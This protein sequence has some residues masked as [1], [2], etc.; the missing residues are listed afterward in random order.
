M[1]AAQPRRVWLVAFVMAVGASVVTHT[2][3]TDSRASLLARA[4]VWMPTRVAEMNVLRGPARPDAFP[5][6]SQ[7]RCTFVDRTLDGNSPKF[8]CVLASGDEIKVKFGD[9]NGEVHGEVAASRLLWALGFGADAMYP[10]RILCDG[11]PST[12]GIPSGPD[13]RLVDPAVVERKMPG[14]EL[15]SGDGP[16]WSWLELD[17]IEEEAGGAT[18]AQRDA[19]KLAAVLLQHTDSKPEQQRLVCLDESDDSATFRCERPFMMINDLGLTFGRA[20]LPNSNLVG[21]VN[22]QEWANTPIW[23]DEGACVGNLAKSLT[24]TLKDPIISEEGRQFLA[25]R[26]TQLSDA[27]IQG[28][29]EVARVDDRAPARGDGR[30]AAPL[31][32][33]VRVFKAKREEIVDRRCNALWPGGISALFGTGPIRWLQERSSPPLTVVMNVISLLG[34][35]R[36]LIAL[37]VMLAFLFKLRAGAALLLLLAFTGVLT[38]GAKAI[39]SSPRPQAVDAAVENLDFVYVLGES[40]RNDSAMPSVDAV[41]GY[42]FPSGHVAMTTAFLFGLGYFFR[43]GWVWPL[44]L[45]W[46]P[47]MAVSR[48]YVGRHFLGDV[49]GG[50]GIGV[51]ASTIGFL[52][53]TLARL[54]NPN[55]A[56]HA[57]VRTFLV[58]VGCVCATLWTGIGAHETGRFL[59]LA[60]AVLLLVNGRFGYVL[61]ARTIDNAPLTARIGRLV[62]AALAFAIVWSATYA[63][64]D[65]FGLR[66]TLAG[67]LLGGA[68][69]AFSLLPLPLVLERVLAAARARVLPAR[70][71]SRRRVPRH[72][73]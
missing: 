39:V 1:G 56:A 27:Q 47:A 23:K 73:T 33:W 59:G 11:C 35:T 20:N 71:R 45:L 43:W 16:G 7:V 49:L 4:H 3:V 42:G 9:S 31:A 72:S 48:V 57:S 29:F 24:G 8:A 44:T 36:V 26:L 50:V 28:I 58:A 5:F 62:L 54:S 14:R 65:G 63:A 6:E 37:G 22:L 46:I 41:D 38:D 2:Q 25:E 21:S 69:P 51:I 32:E 68:V 53:L 60:A 67:A 64:L 40:F 15:A 52:A 70:T 66:Y 13:E 34:Y 30:A 55:R 19:L 10:V 18:R 17:L 12:I 61:A